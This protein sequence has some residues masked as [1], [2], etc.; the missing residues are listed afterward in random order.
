MQKR[1]MN[2]R[3]L[4]RLMIDQRRLSSKNSAGSIIC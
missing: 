1:A 3:A 4:R 2:Y